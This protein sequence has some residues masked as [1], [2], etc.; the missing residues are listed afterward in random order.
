MLEVSAVAGF[1]TGP[2]S[3]QYFNRIAVWRVFANL[4]ADFLAGAVMM[5]ALAIGAIGEGL[6][7]GPAL[8]AAPLF[9]AG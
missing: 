6:G 3:I 9:V 2:F 4:S 1:A 8:S 7:A 5:P